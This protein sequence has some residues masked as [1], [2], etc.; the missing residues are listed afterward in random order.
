[1][2][3]RQGVGTDILIGSVGGS[4]VIRVTLASNSAYTVTLSR[5]V[6]HPN[7]TLEDL[8]DFFVPV[9]VSDGTTTTTNA[10]TSDGLFTRPTLLDLGLAVVGRF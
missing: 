6:D 4:E 1:M 2:Y 8:K 3:K 5:A 7:V 9:S 10:T